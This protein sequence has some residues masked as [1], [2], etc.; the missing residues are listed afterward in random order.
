MTIL[1]QDRLRELLHYDPERGTFIRKAAS[2][3]TKVGDVAGTINRTLGYIFVGVDGKSYLAH[4]LAWLH[5]HGVWPQ[6]VDH[7]N[8]RRTD[9]RIANLRNVDATH[10][11][12]NRR[13]ASSRNKS[14]VL[15]VCWDR[16]R[17]VAHIMVNRK[18]KNLGRYHTVDEAQN[19][20]L[21]AKRQL[22]VG[23]TI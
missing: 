8:G 10:N 17:W 6:V 9:N 12:Q 3:G 23:C 11:T 21:T 7:I 20:Y 2:G 22:H 19:A 14:G 18:R 4:R 16:G 5:F 13:A 15:G 1:T